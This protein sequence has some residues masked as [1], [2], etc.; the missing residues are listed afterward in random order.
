M[1]WRHRWNIEAPE[2]NMIEVKK[3]ESPYLGRKVRVVQQ[4]RVGERRWRTVVEGEVQA[5]GR[6]P[7]GGVEM[8]GKASYCQ[9]ETLMLRRDSG[10]LIEVALDP[11][12]TVEPLS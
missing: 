5:A 4:V 10:E 12:T 6:R 9:Q 7:V 11:E 1:A 2:R 3:I 8:G